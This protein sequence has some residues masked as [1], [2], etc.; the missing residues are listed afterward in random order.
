[1]RLR[2]EGPLARYVAERRWHST[3]VLRPSPDGL[4]C[5]VALTVGHLGEVA[6]WVQSFGGACRVL[7]PAALRRLVCD[8][9]QAG[10]KANGSRGRNLRRGS[11]LSGRQPNKGR[12]HEPES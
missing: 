1:V 4:R 8:G 5:D 3:Q 12:R 10:W 6:A 11:K 2:F 9:H 7:A